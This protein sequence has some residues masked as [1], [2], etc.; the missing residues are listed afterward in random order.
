M[1]CSFAGCDRA[2]VADPMRLSQAP[3][4]CSSA[5]YGP[6][7]AAGCRPQ[8]LP[9]APRLSRLRAPRKDCLTLQG[10]RAQAG[11][12]RRGSSMRRAPWPKAARAS[13]RAAAARPPSP[14]QMDSAAT[15]PSRG[16]ASRAGCPM[17]HAHLPAQA[18]AR[19]GS[20]TSHPVSLRS[21]PRPHGTRP[22]NCCAAPPNRTTSGLLA[23]GFC[24][25]LNRTGRQGGGVKY[26]RLPTT[27]RS[28][29]AVVS[30]VLWGLS[31]LPA[32]TRNVVTSV[33]TSQPI[34]ARHGL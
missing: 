6:D 14:N 20:A 5:G 1:G 15:S 34:G 12:L 17:N 33:W 24:R 25:E 32:T 4:A 26:G 29:P 2:S 8:V 28:V 9:A 22:R 3:P 31:L 19:N 13:G 18:A 27:H 23:L 10:R 16:P 21:S 11:S 30:P 7:E